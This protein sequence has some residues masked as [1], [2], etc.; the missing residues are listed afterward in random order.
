MARERRVAL[1]DSS[2]L[3]L[4]DDDRYI[5]ACTIG[6]HLN[7][8]EHE[9]YWCRDM[10]DPLQKPWIGEA[11]YLKGV[12]RMAFNKWAMIHY[13]NAKNVTRVDLVDIIQHI[14]RP[15]E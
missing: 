13:A 15:T 10:A 12:W 1:H 9:L 5:T 6:A 7:L 4:V 8:I 11:V 14:P 2:E 3:P